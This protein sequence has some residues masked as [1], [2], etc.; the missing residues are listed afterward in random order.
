MIYKNYKVTSFWTTETKINLLDELIEKDKLIEKLKEDLQIEK[1]YALSILKCSEN[2]HS[3]RNMYKDSYK[4]IVNEVL[5]DIL[6]PKIKN[7]SWF[8]KTF[9]D[10]ISVWK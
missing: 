2:L 9:R 10:I 4:K 6:H 1:E 7:T 8:D 5:I 3:E